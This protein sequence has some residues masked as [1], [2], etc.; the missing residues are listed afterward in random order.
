MGLLNRHLISRPLSSSLPRLRSLPRPSAASLLHSV[1]RARPLLS[2]SLL[3]TLLHHLLHEKLLLHGFQLLFVHFLII[4]HWLLRAR[5]V[6]GGLDVDHW[7]LPH[8]AL[9]L[10][11]LW[12]VRHLL[13]F[14]LL[15]NGR[16]V[17]LRLLLSLGQGLLWEIDLAFHLHPLVLSLLFLFLLE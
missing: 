9:L 1:R 2:L 6:R 7:C 16:V 10:R 12:L 8:I 14:W 5:R 3:W 17:G 13:R 11:R 4:L 15:N